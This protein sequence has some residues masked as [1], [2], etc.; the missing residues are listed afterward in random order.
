[1]R[2]RYSIGSAECLN[3]AERLLD[4]ARMLLNKRSFGSAQSL[5]ITA[6]EE[7]GKAIILELANLNYV[8]EKVVEK[9]MTCHLTK[10]TFIKIIEKSIKFHELYVR[11]AGDYA[12]DKSKLYEFEKEIKS[13]TRRLEVMRQDGLYVQVNVVNGSVDKSPI[14]I[15]KRYASNVVE[16]ANSF[17]K[18]G[19]ALCELFRRLKCGEVD[20]VNNIEISKDFRDLNIAW[21]EV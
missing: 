17:L 6:L 16:Y 13:D 4:D 21:D 12:I 9:S 2:A 14:K 3:N 8:D 19:K 1:M 18:L 7:V 10:T 11:K 15:N 5:G 20:Y